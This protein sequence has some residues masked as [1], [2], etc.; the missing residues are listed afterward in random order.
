[1]PIPSAG[2]IDHAGCLELRL[3][4]ETRT[5][6]KSRIATVDTGDMV[7]GMCVTRVVVCT[8]S[9]IEMDGI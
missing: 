7:V 3:G 1:M 5:K 4:R 6:T 8:G 9:W 2:L